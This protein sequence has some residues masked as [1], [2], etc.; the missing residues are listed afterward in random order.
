MSQERQDAGKASRSWV[1]RA[2][3]SKRTSG[4]HVFDSRAELRRYEELRLQEIAG[5]VRNIELQ[6]TFDLAGV[7]YTADFRYERFLEAAEEP[8]RNGGWTT[9]VED[10]KGRRAPREILARFRR[11]AR[12]VLTLYGVTVELVRR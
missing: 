6:P 8:L 11:N 4:G 2:P 5:E 7:R 1:R 10:V 12:Q 3:R 9:V